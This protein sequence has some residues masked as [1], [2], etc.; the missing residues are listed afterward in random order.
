MQITGADRLMPFEGLVHAT[1]RMFA[2]QLHR[3]EDDLEQELRVRVWRA[4][5]SFDG[6]KSPRKDKEAL[7]RYVYSAIANKIK[8]YKRDAAREA[9]RRER[10][11]VSFC[12]IEDTFTLGT[13]DPCQRFDELYNYVDREDVYG[14]VENGPF[15]L[16]AGVTELESHVLLLMML[17]LNKPQIA[18][19]LTVSRAEVEVCVV[20]L[21]EKFRDWKPSN[22]S[23]PVPAELA[24][25]IR[26]AGGRSLGCRR[27]GHKGAAPVD[28]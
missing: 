8:D 20:A 17:D 5:D 4:V 18:I 24:A 16:P 23:R 10:Y 1:A 14:R 15:V 25:V 6:K 26:A 12:H 7:G 13:E 21:R 28:D 11:G 3:E 27:E 22:G 9:R 19:R 2:A